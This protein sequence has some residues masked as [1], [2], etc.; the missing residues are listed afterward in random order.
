M[1]QPIHSFNFKSLQ[2]SDLDLLCRWLD[3]PHVKAWWN[4]ALTHE[5]IKEKYR[6]RIGDKI[7]VPFIVYLN[8]QPIGFIQYYLAN[9][10]GGGWWPDEKEGTIGIDQFI[11]VNELINQ[12]Y[13]QQMI[14]AFAQKMFSNAHI[15]KIILDVN[16]NNVRAIRCYEK[17]GF[18]FVKKILTPDGPAYLMELKRL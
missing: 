14:A 4:D 9:K 18:Q 17:A 1:E 15:K 11:G 7:I 16:P 13:G 3:N 5:A 8:N 12:G 10:V 2:E 6:K